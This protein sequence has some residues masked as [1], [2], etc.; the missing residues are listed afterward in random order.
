MKTLHIERELLP[1]W[2]LI[3]SSVKPFYVQAC[4]RGLHMQLTM[5]G[6]NRHGLKCSLVTNI[7]YCLS[8]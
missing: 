4:E 7:S 5:D 1:V 3:A 2:S 8:F 6:G